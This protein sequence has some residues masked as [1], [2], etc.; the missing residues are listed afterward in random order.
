MAIDR[1][2]ERAVSM[3]SSAMATITAGFLKG[4]AL[5]ETA[6]DLLDMRPTDAAGDCDAEVFGLGAGFGRSDFVGGRLDI[7]GVVDGDCLMTGAGCKGK[8][9]EESV[10]L[11]SV[12]MVK[13]VDMGMR[14]MSC[15]FTNCTCSC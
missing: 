3:N 8:C 7:L 4:D 9:L 14:C 11:G 2:P 1:A 13:G 6:G 12:C 5:L 15:R 10:L